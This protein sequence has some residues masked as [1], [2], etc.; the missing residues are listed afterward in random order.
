MLSKGFVTNSSVWWSYFQH[1]DQGDIDQNMPSDH[2]RFLTGP[3]YHFAL[4][5]EAK[6][7]ISRVNDF[8]SQGKSYGRLE[9][10][11]PVL[12]GL[13]FLCLSQFLLCKEWEDST[14]PV[15]ILLSLKT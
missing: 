6:E 14:V 5:R 12:G 1:T 13:P 3:V 15:L 4:K 7:D 9:N 11:C 10:K 2:I 8:S